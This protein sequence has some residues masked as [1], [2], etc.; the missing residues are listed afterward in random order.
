MR[1]IDVKNMHIMKAIAALIYFDR[2]VFVGKEKKE[3]ITSLL[4]YTDSIKY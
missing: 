2:N 3:K 4:L 1:R